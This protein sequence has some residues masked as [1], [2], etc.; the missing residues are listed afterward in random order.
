M[1]KIDQMISAL[2]KL[3]EKRNTLNKQ[4]IDAEK[5]LAAEAAS[6]AAGAKTKAAA[7]KKPAADKKTVQVKKLVSDNKPAPDKTPVPQEKSNNASGAPKLPLKPLL[8]K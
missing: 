4:I 6:A 8:R 7:K 3:Y 1:A 5:K 2:Q